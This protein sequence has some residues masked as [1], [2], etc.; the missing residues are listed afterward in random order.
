MKPKLIQLIL[1]GT[2]AE[3]IT[4]VG[5]RGSLSAAMAPLE[6]YINRKIERAVKAER[7]A[8][9]KES[10]DKWRYCVDGNE[11]AEFIREREDD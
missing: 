5:R 10:E 2:Y 11:M 9:A 1:Q 3:G 4:L 6:A 7:E 8:C